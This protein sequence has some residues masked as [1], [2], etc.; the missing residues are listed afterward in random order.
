[1]GSDKACDPRGYS[2]LEVL[3]ANLPYA[4]MV[5]LGSGALLVGYGQPAGLDF[6]GRAWIAAGAYLAYGVLGALWIIVFLCPHCPS[7]GSRL[8][9]CGYGTISAKLRPKGNVELF[10][11]KFRRNIPVI[12]PLW[13]I[14]P[15]AGGYFI[16][17]EF[18]WLMVGL[19]AAFAV[20]A[21][22]VLPF[23]SRKHGCERCPQGDD[24][25]WMK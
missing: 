19:L 10:T 3:V 20:D 16:Y 14:P 7:Y 25:P 2:G 15:A 23:Y 21:F 6:D 18:S 8:C 22:L 9:P 13:I 12:V 17:I 5:L 1:M 11:R 24:C 4:A